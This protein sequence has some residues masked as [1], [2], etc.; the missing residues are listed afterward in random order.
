MER[1]HTDVG[2]APAGAGV[3]GDTRAGQVGMREKA[4]P[5]ARAA[6]MGSATIGVAS[7]WA[8]NLV[9]AGD[10]WSSWRVWWLGDATG[11][12][13]VTPAILILARPRPIPRGSRAIVEAVLLAIA[14]A[15]ATV[16]I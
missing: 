15:G 4:G 12:L 10:L 16:F 3:G 5:V 1:T 14:L 7:L 11:A 9:A 2:A 13:I 8:G 6:A